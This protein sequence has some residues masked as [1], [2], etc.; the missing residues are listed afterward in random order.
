MS[1]NGFYRNNYRGGYAKRG[2]GRGRGRGRARGVYNSN[3]FNRGNTSYNN[4]SNQ[5]NSEGLRKKLQS[6]EMAPWN[7][8]KDLR[9]IEWK[10]NNPGFT[11]YFIHI[12]GDPFAGPSK[13]MCKIPL[14]LVGIPEKYYKNDIRNIAL[15]DYLERKFINYCRSKRYDERHTGN[16]HAKKG[17]DITIPTPSQ[18]VLRRMN[19]IIDA[20]KGEL[21]IRFLCALPGKS[22]K[23]LGYFCAEIMCNRV[24][25]VLWNSIYFKNI[26]EAEMAKHILCV[27]D[28]EYLRRHLLDKYGLCAFIPNGAMLARKSG[29]ND[30]PLNSNNAVPFKCDDNDP[31]RIEIIIPINNKRK[32]IGLGIPKGINLIVGGGFHGK[33]TLLNALVYGIYNKI[34]N[35]GRE[36]VSSLSNAVKI[37]AEDGRNIV[38]VN[39]S[40]FIDNLPQ[41]K[42][43]KQFTS[44]N[45]SGS[46]SQAT[47]ICEYIEIGTNLMLFDED[48]CATNF[49]IRDNKMSQLVSKNNEPITPLISKINAMYTKYNI[50][51]ILVIGGCGQYFQIANNVIM[52]HNY[53]P[54][55]VTKKAKE[56]MKNDSN[57]INIF[58]NFGDISNRYID[59]SSIGGRHSGLIK[60][61]MKGKN[62][63][64]NNTTL[65]LSMVESIVETGQINTIAKALIYIKQNILNYNRNKIS[66]NDVLKRIQSD[67]IKNNNSYDILNK[68]ND[69]KYS[70]NKAYWCS[71][72]RSHEIGAALNRLRGITTFNNNN[73]NTPGNTYIKTENNNNNNFADSFDEGKTADDADIDISDM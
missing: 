33:S 40:S 38:D 41:K 25:N 56:I 6:L 2:R 71:F 39:I 69:Q 54:I 36:F 37:R 57:T 59:G 21:E 67:I 19:I 49:M 62:I 13:M 72:V 32:L 26:N 70:Y 45:G 9:N 22:R 55:N 29:V 8:Y 65:D 24:P 3:D 47:N 53:L 20:K 48:I 51:C 27:E 68:V 61:K 42:S 1:N 63:L 66:L 17:G 4:N 11:L 10:F 30:T 16:F 73:S 31:L 43:T 5:N 60:M 23:I 7:Y 58:N 12:Q 15:C 14:K 64:F 52:M 44:V 50:S 35:D 28:Q 46:T 34:P 18:N